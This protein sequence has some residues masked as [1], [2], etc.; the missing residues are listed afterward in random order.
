MLMIDKESTVK[1]ITE[2]LC[3]PPSAVRNNQ[4]EEGKVNLVEN[5]TGVISKAMKGL[6]K[7]KSKSK[8]LFTHVK[9]SNKMY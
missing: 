9:M 7:S 4:V 5:M 3:S 2:K 8:F 1:D 6:A